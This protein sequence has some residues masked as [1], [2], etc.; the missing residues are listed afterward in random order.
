MKLSREGFT[1]DV[2][3]AFVRRIVF[4][5]ALAVTAAVAQTMI[6][7]IQVSYN[8]DFLQQTPKFTWPLASSVSLWVLL[9]I[10]LW[11][12]DYL[13]DGYANNW[14][15]DPLWDWSKEIVLITGA[16]SGI[17]ASIVQ[18]LIQRNP[19]ATIVIL[20]YSP[21]SWTPP[22]VSKIHFY[23]CDLSHSS[24]IKAIS[25]K[26]R[27]EVGHPTVLV[28]NAGLS[29]GFTVMDGSYADVDVTIRTN[30]LAPFLL[31]KEFLPYLVQHNH[32]HI[33]NI[34]SMSSIMPPAGI[35]DYAATKSGINALHQVRWFESSELRWN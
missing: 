7:F 35:A 19:R 2:A 9:S 5:P 22:P 31:T 14:A 11:A 24:V 21:M 15:A 34:S 29:R 13:N 27:Q 20:D 30:L 26:I 17:G 12:N 33:M 10:L 8:D 28:N 23:Q 3:A 16:S 18:H 1:I 4:N 6:H 25:E 32:G